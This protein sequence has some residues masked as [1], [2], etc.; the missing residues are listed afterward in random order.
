M[1]CISLC[2]IQSCIKKDTLQACWISQKSTETPFFSS[3]V[4]SKRYKLRCKFQHFV[5]SAALDASYH[6]AGV[7]Y[8]IDYINNKFQTL[9]TLMQDIAV[10]ESLTLMQDITVD[11]SLMK[12]CGRLSF[13][14]FNPTKQA[15]FGVKYYKLCESSSSHCAQFRIYS[16]DSE[17]PC[18][19]QL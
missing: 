14:Q 13:I 10:D 19:R 17:P 16:W 4:S 7:E 2:I 8:P 18:M 9:Y 6:L 11:E 3:V 15:H 12:L 5:D 1:A